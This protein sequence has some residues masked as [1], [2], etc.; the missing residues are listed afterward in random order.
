MGTCFLT[1]GKSIQRNLVFD[2]E[3]DHEGCVI[4][5]HAG[6]VETGL[7]HIPGVDQE[8]VLATVAKYTSLRFLQYLDILQKSTVLK[9]Y[10]C[11][12]LLNGELT[13]ELYI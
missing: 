3:R 5:H 10:V 2:L 4:S 1:E 7:T 8:G 9:L 11:N 13:K 12:V 6:M